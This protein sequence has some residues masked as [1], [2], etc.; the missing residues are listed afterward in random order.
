[1]RN[2]VCIQMWSGSIFRIIT[3][4]P[5]VRFIVM[6]HKIKSST[7][8]SVAFLMIWAIQ[9]PFKIKEHNRGKMDAGNRPPVYGCAQSVADACA[10][11]IAPATIAPGRGSSLI[12]CS[13]ANAAVEDASSNAPSL[14]LRMYLEVINCTSRVPSART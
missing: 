8:L 1:M 6:Y 12:S 11:N 7:C 4:A 3:D 13:A 2:G 5:Y 9:Q 10:I 14:V